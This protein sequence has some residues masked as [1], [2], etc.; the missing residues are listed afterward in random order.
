MNPSSD[1]ESDNWVALPVEGG[2]P[3]A[4]PPV[5]MTEVIKERK[6]FN[7]LP[8]WARMEI[9]RLRKELGDSRCESE[10]RGNI[11]CDDHRWR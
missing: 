5:D 9:L 3:M 4:D 8:K 6:R 1:T 11:T 2:I 7:A 10:Y